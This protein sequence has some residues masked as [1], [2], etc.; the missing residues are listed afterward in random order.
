MK[1]KIL[2]IFGFIV[3]SLSTMTFANGELIPEWVKNNAEWWAEGKIDQQAFI[4]GIEYLVNQGI[5]SIPIQH[6]SVGKSDSVP[7]W[8]KNTAEWW[9]QGKIPDSAF[10]DGIEFLVKEGIIQIEYDSEKLAETK[11][12]ITNKITSNENLTFT[13]K[14]ILLDKNLP[15]I[16]G[17]R[18]AAFD[19]ESVYF[20]P[21]YNNY[22]RQFGFMLKYNINLPFENPDSWEIFNLGFYGE[23]GGFQ[24]A[25]Y[26]NGFVHYVPYVLNDS[27]KQSN[28]IGSSTQFVRYDT[29]KKFNELNAWIFTPVNNA[30]MF[31]DG[32]VVNNSVYFAPHFDQSEK[33]FAAPLRFDTTETSFEKAFVQ[34]ISGLKISYIGAS[35]DG[36]FIYYAPSQS[37]YQDKT[38]ILIHDI[39]KEFSDSSSWTEI[40]IPYTQLSGTGFNGKEI[41]MAPHCYSNASTNEIEVC[42]KILF[43][44]K[45]TQEIT[46]SDKSYGSYNGVIEADDKLFLV[47]YMSKDIHTDFLMIK[48][49]IIHSFTPSIATGGYWGGTYDGRHV[50]YVPY[51]FVDSPTLRNG[52]FLRYD[53]TQNFDDELAWEMVSF[54]VTDFYYDYELNKKPE[55]TVHPEEFAK[56]R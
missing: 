22:E 50:Y 17:Y 29:S 55:N 5:I 15:F 56:F 13:E 20:A 35:F 14:F 53:T 37:D 38:I 36:N 32:V 9:S 3:F 28:G 16:S 46:Y 1:F 31:E 21:Y 39:S 12:I 7:D 34:Y 47:P 33:R 43:L 27:D 51:N 42:P 54:S 11:N 23:F 25:M 49:G 44:N 2:F 26:S 52:D 24:G 6:T 40:T 19:G 4:Q 48:D 41:V 30:G 45:E 8:I 10:I 18:G